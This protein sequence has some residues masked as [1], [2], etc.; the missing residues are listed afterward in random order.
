MTSVAWRTAFG[1]S[2]SDRG[3]GVA[4]SATEL[5]LCGAT[6][7][8]DD[9]FPLQEAILDN[10]GDPASY[11]DFFQPWNQG[12]EAGPEIVPGYHF[13]QIVSNSSPRE[14]PAELPWLGHDAV[15]AAFGLLEETGVGLPDR[16]SSGLRFATLSAEGH[17]LVHFPASAA[18]RLELFDALGRSLRSTRVVDDKAYIDLSAHAP[19]AYLLRATDANGQALTAKL[20]RP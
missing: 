9:D 15:I 5:Y 11:L 13:S 1:G 7:S 10:P 14:A 12:G 3:W 16:A 2:Q 8:L 19:G 20:I 17:Y 18:W 6:A 4:A